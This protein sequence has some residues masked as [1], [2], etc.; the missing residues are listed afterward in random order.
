[1]RRQ[2]CQCANQRLANRDYIG[3]LE[4]TPEPLPV[5]VGGELRDAGSEGFDVVIVRYLS[6]V[7]GQGNMT[8]SY[9]SATIGSTRTARRAG[10]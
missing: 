4:K 5:Q 10:T 6:R 9:L 8:Y 1:M 3:L 2:P 7:P